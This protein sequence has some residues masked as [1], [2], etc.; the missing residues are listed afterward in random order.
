M[1]RAGLMLALV[2]LAGCSTT[3]DTAAPPS[4]LPDFERGARLEVAWR[5][6]TGDA[7]NERWV[8]MAPR[9]GEGALYAANVAGQVTR[10]DPD[11]G[12]R[13][14][15]TDVDAWL[16]A[17]VGGGDGGVYVATNEGTLIALSAEDGS[18]RWRR[19]VGGELLAP[20]ATATDL[21]VVRTVD[22]RVLALDPADG[23]RVWTYSG[24]VPSL[25]LRG[26]S[27]PVPVEGGVLV[28]LDNGRLVALHEGA[29][30]PLWETAI[31]AP[32]GRS[33]IER[34]VDIDGTLGIGRGVV[35]AAT[36]QGSIAQVE[37]REGNIQWSRQMSSYA[38]LTVDGE[39]VYV[40]DAASHV[41]ALDPDGG[42][43]LWRQEK[44]AHRRLTAPVPVP[45]TDYLALADYNG[46]VHILAR[47][48]G[49]IVARTRAGDSFGILADPVPT[50]EGRFVVQARGAHIVSLRV[51]PLD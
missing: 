1:R 17:G 37:P 40:T 32:E 13:A 16:S 38:G 6:G 34:M 3:E 48:D 2:L 7:F 44:L 31:Q 39:R 10:W 30:R 51:G 25:S 8:R 14:W 9:F 11:D 4:E 23:E 43:T 47:A 18:E 46:Y 27:Q 35:Y 15:R 29:G 36:Y 21:V 33:P 19:D 49:R 50:G 26:N 12:D 45:G 20:P 24:D 5:D 42:A 22:G 28:G 41:R